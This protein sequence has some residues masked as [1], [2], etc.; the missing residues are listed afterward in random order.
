MSHGY[1]YKVHKAHK[2][3]IIKRYNYNKIQNL[4]FDGLSSI[5]AKDLVL[6]SDDSDDEDVEYKGHFCSGCSIPP[7]G[8]WG[9]AW[10]GSWVW[11]CWVVGGLVGSR[12]WVCVLRRLR[13]KE[14]ESLGF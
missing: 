13:L 1:G 2:D 12:S 7:P 11:W 4:D 9:C 8:G 3:I 10:V 14:C 5:V 6:V